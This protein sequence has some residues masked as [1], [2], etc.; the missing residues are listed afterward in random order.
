[1][2]MMHRVDGNERTRRD[3]ID[4]RTPADFATQVADAFFHDDPKLAGLFRE[5]I[6]HGSEEDVPEQL[7]RVMSERGVSDRITFV[8]VLRGANVSVAANGQSRYIVSNRLRGCFLTVLAAEAENGT[9]TVQLTHFP[10]F[11]SEKQ[12]ARMRELGAELSQA[13]R[14]SAVIVHGS[15]R[16]SQSTVEQLEA[17]LRSV[18]PAPVELPIRFQS[19]TIDRTKEDSGVFIVGIPPQNSGNSISTYSWD[20]NNHTIDL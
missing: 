14:S 7:Q 15:H 5:R 16:R 19:Y 11:A 18:N 2:S 6:L 1:M 12:Q 13:E 17:T 4:R 9:R 3:G 10:S 20:G 8:D